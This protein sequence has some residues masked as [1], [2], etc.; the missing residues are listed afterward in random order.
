MYVQLLS[1]MYDNIPK[2][3]MYVMYVKCTYIMYLCSFCMPEGPL[4]YELILLVTYSYFILSDIF[5]ISISNKSRLTYN[6][7]LDLCK[8]RKANGICS[9]F[10]PGIFKESLLSLTSLYSLRMKSFQYRTA[11]SSKIKVKIA[12]LFFF[13]FSFFLS[14]KITYRK[15]M[16]GSIINK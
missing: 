2:L 12:H 4:E 14:L 15:M 7:S 6:I 11:A 13:F 8:K 9:Y 10:F 3:C 5:P 1:I 16:V